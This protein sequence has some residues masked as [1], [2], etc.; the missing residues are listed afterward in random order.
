MSGSVAALHPAAGA[1]TYTAQNQ[2]RCTAAIDCSLNGV[3][4][5]GQ[6]SCDAAWTGPHCD[7]L[8]FTAASRR[9]GYRRASASG[10]NFS[11]WGGSVL[12][13]ETDRRWHMW[14]SEFVSHCGLD[15]WQSN[16]RISHAVSDELAGDFTFVGEVVP[17]FAHNPTVVR[18]ERGE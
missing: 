17:V 5:S 1:V 7:R 4:V 9:G 3:C 12:F 15:S 13:S 2:H 6:C 10:A 11:S 8:A 16:S 18:G 14:V